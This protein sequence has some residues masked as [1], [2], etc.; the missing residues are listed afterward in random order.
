MSASVKH[1]M[2]FT[3]VD[4]K[5]CNAV[6][7]TK[8]TMRRYISGATSR[9]FNDL[10]IKKDVDDEALSFGLS[11]LHASIRLF[12]SILHLCYKIPVKTWQLRSEADKT[13]VKERIAEI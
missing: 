11:I 8:S 10:T 2:T 1:S 12:E 13:V 9:F 4:G 7:Q 3:M 5:V 6:T